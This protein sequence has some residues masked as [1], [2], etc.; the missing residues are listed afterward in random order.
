MTEQLTQEVAPTESAAKAP[1]QAS[2]E[3][4]QKPPRP[5]KPVTLFGVILMQIITFAAGLS[6]AYVLMELKP[7]NELKIVSVD[8]AAIISAKMFDMQGQDLTSDEF[9][10]SSE[11]FVVKLLSVLDDYKARGYT[12]IN[13]QAL[14]VTQEGVN[15]T[16][17]LAAQV[18]VNP[19]AISESQRGKLGRE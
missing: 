2:E 1:A 5:E 18:G 11:K 17:E 7:S 4:K 9:R 8:T 3:V 12:V 15:I 16:K 14:I 19:R 13:D 6:C 10:A